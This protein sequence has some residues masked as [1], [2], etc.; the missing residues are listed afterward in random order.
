MTNSVLTYLS[1]HLWMYCIGRDMRRL[2]LASGVTAQCLKHLAKSN[3]L[4]SV[5]R[6]VCNMGREMLESRYTERP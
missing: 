5:R 6:L 4:A 2:I 3:I 1:V